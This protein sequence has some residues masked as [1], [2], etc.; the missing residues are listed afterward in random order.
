MVLN[1]HLGRNAA[2]NPPVEASYPKPVVFF[3]MPGCAW[4]AKA[5]LFFGFI[6]CQVAR[7]CVFSFYFAGCSVLGL[8]FRL[9]P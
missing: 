6:C 1:R 3:Q 4:E 9:L 2:F 5:W 7:V 8:L